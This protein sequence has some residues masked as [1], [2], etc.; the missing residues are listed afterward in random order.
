MSQSSLRS[1]IDVLLLQC[2]I[3]GAGEGESE[4]FFFISFDWFKL[5]IYDGFLSYQYGDFV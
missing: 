4:V 2:Q 1:S 5:G 3:K